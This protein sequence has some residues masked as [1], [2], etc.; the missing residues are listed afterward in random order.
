MFENTFVLITLIL[1]GYFSKRFNFLKKED[2]KVLTKI[3][4]YFMLPVLI[5]GNFSKTNINMNFIYFSLSSFIMLT[6]FLIIG[7]FILLFLKLNKK[8][9][10]SF[11][12]MFGS[13][14]GA[15]LAYP[16]ILSNYGEIGFSKFLFYDLILTFF[17][18]T[19]LNYIAVSDKKFN[20]KNNL[21]KL[22]KNPMFIALPIALILNLLNFQ[23]SFTDKL[24]EII[25]S[26][27]ILIGLLIVGLNLDFNISDFKL[28]LFLISLKLIIGIILAYFVIYLFNFQGMDKSI[29]LIAGTLPPSLMAM[30][31]SEQYNLDTKFV[32]NTLSLGLPISL[33]VMSIIVYIF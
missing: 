1:I 12:I 23:S 24:F 25:P 20:L 31:Y 16:F 22:L 3:L 6:L 28:P 13:F 29:I 17:I 33:I 11:L 15:T 21:F 7:Y 8:T 18:V 9:S 32:A 30:I 19:V 4:L 14:W 2:G 26:G 10:K 5:L 27:I